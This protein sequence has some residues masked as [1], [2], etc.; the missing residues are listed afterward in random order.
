MGRRR[1]RRRGRRRGGP[2]RASRCRRPSP[3]PAAVVDP[4]HLHLHPLLP[5]PPLAARRRGGSRRRPQAPRRARAQLSRRVHLLQR[6]VPGR[7]GWGW[8]RV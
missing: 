6:V 4:A 5:H 7:W 3:S 1:R 2:P 8:Q